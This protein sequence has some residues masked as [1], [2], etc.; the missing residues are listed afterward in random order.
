MLDS[1]GVTEGKHSPAKRWALRFASGW[2]GAA[3][4][5]NCPPSGKIEILSLKP[6]TLLSRITGD[7]ADLADHP[8]RRSFERALQ[9]IAS[10]KD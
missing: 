8:G 7:L 10:K 9:S 3:V 2:H 1:T 4:F 5:D 6:P